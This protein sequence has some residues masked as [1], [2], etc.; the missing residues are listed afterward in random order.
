M[1]T[2]HTQT[3]SNLS[4]VEIIWTSMAN[5]FFLY[6]TL[7]FFDIVLFYVWTIQNRTVI[8]SLCDIYKFHVKI[9]KTCN[10]NYHCFLM[11]ETMR[12]QIRLSQS[13]FANINPK[14]RR[15]TKRKFDSLIVAGEN[16][17]RFFFIGKWHFMVFNLIHR[18]FRF[19]WIVSISKTSI[20]MKF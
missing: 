8:E 7:S 16:S 13:F 18:F 15:N 3:R 11:Q 20:S 5:S 9:R 10:Y 4:I 17:K 2:A 19:H 1:Q 6:Q 14:L 12:T